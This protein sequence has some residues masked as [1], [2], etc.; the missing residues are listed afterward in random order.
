M[1]PLLEWDIMKYNGDI[2]GFFFFL[3][4]HS[5]CEVTTKINDSMVNEVKS[6]FRG[7]R[8]I[9]DERND[10]EHST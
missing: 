3:N 2:V 1:K 5:W 7:K 10:Q 9:D 8:R 4:R 6:I